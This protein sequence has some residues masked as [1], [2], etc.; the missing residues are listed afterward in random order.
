[1]ARQVLIEKAAAPGRTKWH[2]WDSAT[3]ANITKFVLG[4]CDLRRDPTLP[5]KLE[6]YPRSSGCFQHPITVDFNELTTASK[7]AQAD[8]SALIDY[9]ADNGFFQ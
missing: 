8:M 9:F 6:I 4:E 2:E 3:P 7:Y 5:Q 1:M